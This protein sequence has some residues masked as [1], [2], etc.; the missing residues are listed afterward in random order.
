M[1]PLNGGGGGKGISRVN[2]DV[3]KE[4]YTVVGNGFYFF[5]LCV[6]VWWVA[7]NK[8]Q[9]CVGGPGMFLKAVY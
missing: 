4:K 8:L 9:V 5:F 3:E 6:C 1:C 7:L 2:W